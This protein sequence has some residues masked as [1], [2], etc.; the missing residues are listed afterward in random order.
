MR[1][2]GSSPVA[3]A[4]T[5]CRAQRFTHRGRVRSGRSL[6][7]ALVPARATAARRGGHL[8]AYA[9]GVRSLGSSPVVLAP[10]VSR[11]H[12]TRF[13]PHAFPVAS[14]ARSQ[15][16]GSRSRRIGR[17]GR[18]SPRGVP[19]ACPKPDPLRIPVALNRLSRIWPVTGYNRG[20]CG[21]ISRWRR[22][23]DAR[24]RMTLPTPGVP[25]A[26]QP[27]PR[28]NPSHG[29]GIPRSLGCDRPAGC[30]GPAAATAPP[31]CIRPAAATTRHGAST[32][33]TRN[34]EVVD[35][36]RG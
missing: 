16:A 21:A 26:G 11:A 24:A 1:S 14:A 8:V 28:P 13:P 5:V 10:T 19:A 30:E 2:L 9:P 7:T 34:E 15:R 22:L 31:R 25:T 20:A 36:V 6:G 33:S 3:L 35:E 27:S 23:P 29:I 4:S 18:V 12:G 32:A 17:V